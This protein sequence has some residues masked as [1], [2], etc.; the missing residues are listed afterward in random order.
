MI[1]NVGLLTPDNLYRLGDAY[2]LYRNRDASADTD[3]AVAFRTKYSRM[4]QVR[5][6]G[7]WDT[8]GALGIPISALQWLN[9]AVYSFHDTE[10]SSI[11]RT[12]VQAV[13]VDEHRVDYPGDAVDSN[14][15]GGTERRATL[16]PGLPWRCRRWLR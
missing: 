13:A 10:L 4:I 14:S 8:V 3:A 12:A 1:R 15:Q 9:S 7:V 6:L 5:F 2:A 11:V 16:V